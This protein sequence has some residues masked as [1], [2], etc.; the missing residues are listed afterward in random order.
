M[1]KMV[2]EAVATAKGDI[3]KMD[4]VKLIAADGSEI[5][6]DRRAANVSGTI[7]NM[8]SGPGNFS[9]AQQGEVKFPEISAKTLET[10]V[11]V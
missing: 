2:N 8:L 9:E 3:Y 1:Q 7:K 5:I 6:L 10:V 11:Q 4:P